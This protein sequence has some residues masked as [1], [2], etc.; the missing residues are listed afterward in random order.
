[1]KAPPI[2]PTWKMNPRFKRGFTL[3]ELLVVIAI[4]AILASMLLPALAR[5]KSRA[6]QTA[7]LNNLRQL[8]I[9]TIMYVQ[10]SRKYPGCLWLEGGF[11]YIWP[12]R[13]FSQMGTNRNVFWCPAANPNSSMDRSVNNTLGAN[14]PSSLGG[15]IDL[16]G[17]KETTR[18]SLGYNDW[19]TK[20]PGAS[21]SGQLGLGGDVNIVGEVVESAVK[22]PSEM[23]ML[24]DSRPGSASGTGAFFDG[25]IDPK[26]PDEW[27]S[28]RHNRRTN[29]M[30]ADGHAESARRKDV[31]D[32]TNDTWA[33]RWN[34]NNER[35]GTWTVDPNL[36]SRLDP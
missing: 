18:F 8:G 3:I 33:R 28:N 2:K 10:E 30:F 22:R 34:N 23:I 35:Y 11:Y 25:N 24:G 9:A 6:K 12:G 36:E 7:C 21:L 20:D 26:N 32:P 5:A 4:I 13:L 19:G 27:P 29:L 1:M 14:I 16:Y 31:I 15:G 17:V